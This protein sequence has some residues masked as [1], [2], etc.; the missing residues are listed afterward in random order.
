[1]AGSRQLWVHHRF[2]EGLN[3]IERRVD[4]AKPCVSDR[5]VRLNGRAAAL[6]G[7][8]FFLVDHDNRPPPGASAFPGRRV[9][10]DRLAN[11]FE[12]AGL[13][14]RPIEFSEYRITAATSTENHGSS[15]SVFDSSLAAVFGGWFGWRKKQ[16]V[17]SE[18]GPWPYRARAPFE[19]VLE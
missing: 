16:A 3:C 6:R 18:P 11:C 13:A 9:P 2:V 4:D 5:Q 15:R 12:L 19:S 17:A 14:W 8:L 10:G 7:N 1:M